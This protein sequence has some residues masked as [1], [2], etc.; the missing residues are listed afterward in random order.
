MDRR[1]DA[2]RLLSLQLGSEDD[3]SPSPLAN[4]MPTPDSNSTFSIHLSMQQLCRAGRECKL[5]VTNSNKGI[6]AMVSLL[7]HCSPWLLSVLCPRPSRSP[8]PLPQLLIAALTGKRRLLK[9]PSRQKSYDTPALP[10]GL[11]HRVS[12]SFSPSH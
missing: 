1:R 12:F 2:E 11:L 7:F 3:A 4:S 5:A 6:Q 8:Q 10:R 9:V